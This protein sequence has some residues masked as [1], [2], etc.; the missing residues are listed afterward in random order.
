[1]IFKLN[2]LKLV[3]FIQAAYECSKINQNTNGLNYIDAKRNSHKCKRT[4]SNYVD[5]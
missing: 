5:C 4:T 2:K 3:H 1:M